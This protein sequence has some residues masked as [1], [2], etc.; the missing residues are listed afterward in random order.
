MFT[1][2]QPATVNF[3]KLELTILINYTCVVV[4]TFIR[5]TMA[6]SAHKLHPFFHQQC[7]TKKKITKV[8]SP[9]NT[10]EFSTHQSQVDTFQL[11]FNMQ[12]KLVFT[13]FFLSLSFIFLLLVFDLSFST[14]I[15]WGE[16]ILFHTYIFFALVEVSLCMYVVDLCVAYIHALY[17]TRWNLHISQMT[18]Y[19]TF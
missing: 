5:H 14:Q 8:K 13:L 15:H 11:L 9:F 16:D 1:N 2:T 6:E 7:E 17:S 18:M 3:N 12:I 4:L 10:I 19:S